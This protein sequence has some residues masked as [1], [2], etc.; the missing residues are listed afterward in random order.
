MPRDLGVPD[1][2]E[3]VGDLIEEPL[4]V[5]ARAEAALA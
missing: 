2:V 3:G 1:E 4:L 5:L